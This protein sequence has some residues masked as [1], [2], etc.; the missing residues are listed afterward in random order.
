M[1]VDAYLAI[2][3]M[4]DSIRSKSRCFASLQPLI[5][6]DRLAY[7]FHVADYRLRLFASG[8]FSD[9]GTHFPYRIWPLRSQS[10]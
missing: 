2:A 9:S 8:Q 4:I 6:W 7:W 1:D 3:W 10:G 5:C